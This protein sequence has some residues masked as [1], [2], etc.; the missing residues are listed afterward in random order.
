MCDRCHGYSAV[1][2]VPK[3]EAEPTFELPRVLTA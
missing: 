1:S 3:R 2:R